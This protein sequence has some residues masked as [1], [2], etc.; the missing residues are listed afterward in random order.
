[1][2]R[3]N[4]FACLDGE[5]DLRRCCDEILVVGIND[6]DFLG[7]GVY[8]HVGDGAQSVWCE[9]GLHLFNLIG[10]TRT[11]GFG[12]Q[13]DPTVWLMAF[14]LGCIEPF[15]GEIP[16]GIQRDQ[17]IVANGEA[18]G[19]E[20]PVYRDKV[21]PVDLD[22]ERFIGDCDDMPFC[23]ARVNGSWGVLQ[24]TGTPPASGHVV[25][26]RTRRGNE[27]QV[28]AAPPTHGRNSRT[29]IGRRGVRSF[30]VL[31]LAHRKT[32]EIQPEKAEFDISPA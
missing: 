16:A 1:M 14:S 27:R 30:D 11:I 20:C 28:T 7:L 4:G 12:R 17:N 8:E 26:G 24:K 29:L 25:A 2:G 15:I 13:W 32:G 10:Q 3:A 5:A 23:G 21:R 6:L 18:Q 31:I 9:H 22:N 19:C